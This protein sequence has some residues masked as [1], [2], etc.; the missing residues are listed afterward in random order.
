MVFTVRSAL[1]ATSEFGDADAESLFHAHHQL[2]RVDRVQAQTVRAEK[3]KVVSN[4]ISRRLEHQ[5]LDQHFL[6]AGA[7]ICFGHKRAAKV[8][9]EAA[10]STLQ[11]RP[12]SRVTSRHSGV[13]TTVLRV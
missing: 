13:A 4:L 11:P 9:Q 12:L 2:E 8:S 10:K 5:I 6:N 7:E 3:R 1:P